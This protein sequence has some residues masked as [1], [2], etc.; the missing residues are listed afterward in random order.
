MNLKLLGVNGE[1]SDTIF[2]VLHIPPKYLW[3]YSNQIDVNLTNYKTHRY[4]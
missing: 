2:D 3:I 1:I 4:D